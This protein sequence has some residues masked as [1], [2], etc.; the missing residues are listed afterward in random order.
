MEKAV[1]PDQLAADLDLQFS[2]EDIVGN[3]FQVLNSI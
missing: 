1:D 3:P 2:K